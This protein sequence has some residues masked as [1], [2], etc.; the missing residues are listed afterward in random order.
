M[1]SL[2]LYK[3]RKHTVIKIGARDFKIPNEYTVE[4]AERLLEMQHKREA[5]ESQE[6]ASPE[7]QIPEFWGIV[8][9]QLEIIFQHYQPDMDI[10]QLKKLVSHNEALHILGFFDKYRQSQQKP[11]ETKKKSLNAN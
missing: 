11:A 10:D 8:F 3:G 4:E 5:L 9:D 2:D 7:S 1:N 6:A